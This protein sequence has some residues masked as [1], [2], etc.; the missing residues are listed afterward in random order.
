[1]GGGWGNNG[2]CFENNQFGHEKAKMINKSKRKKNT[3]DSRFRCIIL[4]DF[5]KL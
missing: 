4:N 5:D 1:M 3:G 2:K